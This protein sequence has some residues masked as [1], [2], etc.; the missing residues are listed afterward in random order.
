MHALDDFRLDFRLGSVATMPENWLL[1]A[2]FGGK[3][4]WRRRRK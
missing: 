3:T 1:A 4:R 2:Y